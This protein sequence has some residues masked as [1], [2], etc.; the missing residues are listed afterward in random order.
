LCENCIIF[1][2]SKSARQRYILEIKFNNLL[3]KTNNLIIGTTDKM[4]DLIEKDSL[5]DLLKKFYLFIYLCFF[6]IEVYVIFIHMIFIGVIERIWIVR[7]WLTF[8]HWIK[9]ELFKFKII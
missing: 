2:S 7:C 8:N 1:Y 9:I 4:L 5:K 6:V 3:R